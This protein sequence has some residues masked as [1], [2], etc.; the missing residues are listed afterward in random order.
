MPRMKSIDF[1]GVKL[2]RSEQ[3]ERPET[4]RGRTSTF[5]D[6]TDNPFFEDVV[7]T[8]QNGKTRRLDVPKDLVV[9]VE[10]GIR[11][12]L[13]LA[14]KMLSAPNDGSDNAIEQAALRKQYFGADG[15][16]ENIGVS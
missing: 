10:R 5:V 2:S 3:T 6:P 9:D 4:R 1:K 7:Q 11:Q 16:S 14:N 13:T 8:Y 15:P 12:A